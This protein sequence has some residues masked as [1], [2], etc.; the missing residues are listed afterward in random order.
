MPVLSLPGGQGDLS[1]CTSGK[2]QCVPKKYVKEPFYHWQTWNAVRQK[3]SWIVYLELYMACLIIGAVLNFIRA[4]QNFVTG[5]DQIAIESASE[6]WKRAVPRL[7]QSI[8]STSGEFR[9]IF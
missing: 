3:P 1:Q 9:P 2:G 7:S 5:K 4:E 8:A 6:Q